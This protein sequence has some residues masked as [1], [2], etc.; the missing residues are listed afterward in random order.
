MAGSPDEIVEVIA[1]YAEAGVDELI[2]PN[3][4]MGSTNEVNE[5]YDSWMHDV[6]RQ[7]G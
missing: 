7:L 1:Q 5:T 6:I 3:F 4:N 2:V